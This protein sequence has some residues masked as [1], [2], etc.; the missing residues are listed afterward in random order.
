MYTFTKS[1]DRELGAGESD[2]VVVRERHVRALKE[3]ASALGRLRKGREDEKTLDVLV[4]ELDS[5]VR[6]LGHILG[7]DVDVELLDE[8]FGQFCIGK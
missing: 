5:A 1:G 2:L 7:R 8:I 3:A 4:M 6:S